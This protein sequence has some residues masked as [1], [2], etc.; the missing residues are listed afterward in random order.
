MSIE[1]YNQN[2]DNFFENT[3]NVDMSALYDEFTQHLPE[4]AKILD[5]G[6]GSGR[7]SKAFVDMGYDVTAIDASAEMVR[8]ATTHAGIKVHQLR[9]DEIPWT[10]TF[11]GI[12]SCASLLHVKRR[13]LPKTLETIA[14]ALKPNGSWYASFKYGNS[15]REK[16]GRHFTDLDEA[17]FAE[18]I[19]DL[20]GIEIA[21]VW[22]TV[23]KRPDRDERWLNVMLRKTGK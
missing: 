1:F 8:R 3:V 16:E 4:G 10:E 15:E 11:D 14:N 6:C 2:A 22:I 13:E 21:K 19:D 9:F 18:L 17:Q 12:W 7:D 23:D 20:P 5:A